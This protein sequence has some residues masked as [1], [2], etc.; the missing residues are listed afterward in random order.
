[1]DLS[2]ILLYSGLRLPSLQH[3]TLDRCSQDEIG[4]LALSP[5]SES[6]PPRELDVHLHPDL[7]V[8]PSLRLLGVPNDGKDIIQ[9]L[10]HNHSLTHLCTFF[11]SP[12]ADF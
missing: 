9:P 11:I 12:M 8:L 3:I 5:L 2:N 4:T 10:P 7:S 6:I 1:M